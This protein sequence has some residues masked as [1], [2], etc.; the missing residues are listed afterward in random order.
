MQPQNCGVCGGRS[1]SSASSTSDKQR[2]DDDPTSAA[3]SAA[4]TAGGTLQSPRLDNLNKAPSRRDA[5]ENEGDGY[6]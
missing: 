5:E 6:S 3:V 2:P 1:T 4:A